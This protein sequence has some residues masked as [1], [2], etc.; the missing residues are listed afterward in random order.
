[1]SSK[2][3]ISC[4]TYPRDCFQFDTLYL[5]PSTNISPLVG[6]IK[7]IIKS[8]RVLFPAPDFPVIP[9]ISPFLISKLIFFKTKLSP[10]GYLYP[11]FFSS[12]F[13]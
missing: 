8:I 6:E 10:L 1:M 13:F 11:T 5:L 4:G 3:N 7:P 2:T 12:I 9:I